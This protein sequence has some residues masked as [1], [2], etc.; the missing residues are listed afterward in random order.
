MVIEGHKIWEIVIKFINSIKFKYLSHIW[1]VK[2]L[3]RIQLTVSSTYPVLLRT[4]QTSVKSVKQTST[5]HDFSRNWLKTDHAQL[6]K[7]TS[8]DI[9]YHDH[10]SLWSIKRGKQNSKRS[11][12]LMDEFNQYFLINPLK[13]RAVWNPDLFLFY[14]ILSYLILSHLISSHYLIFDGQPWHHH[15]GLQIPPLF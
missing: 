11:N 12:K 7:Q 1:L 4:Q 3:F 14:L 10:S 2:V 15:A 5:D 6:K 13:I 9:I 8:L